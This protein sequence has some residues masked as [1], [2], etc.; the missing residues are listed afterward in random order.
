MSHLVPRLRIFLS[1]PSDLVA[2]R[3]V[4]LKV[5]DELHYDRD[6]AGKVLLEPVACG[7]GANGAASSRT[8]SKAGCARWRKM[9]DWPHS[10]AHRLAEA[11]AF[12]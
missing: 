1:S 6:L 7:R 8:P 11:G 10:P 9:S 2:E 3:Q 12:R 5:I 4:A